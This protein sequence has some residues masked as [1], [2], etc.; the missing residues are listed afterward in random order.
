MRISVS[1]TRGKTTTVNMLHDMLRSRGLSVI[2]KTTGERAVVRDNTE[3]EIAE[4]PRSVLYENLNIIKSNYDIIIVE[5]QAIT[6]YTMRAFNLMVKPDIVIITNVRLDHTE[7]LG[8][9]REDIARSFCSSFVKSIKT[10]ISGEKRQEIGEILKKGAEKIGAS[11]VKAEDYEIPGS[12][13]VGIAEAVL[14]HVFGERM[15]YDE[16][17][18]MLK[19]LD[20]MFSARKSRSLFWY[21][22]AKI[23]DPDSAEIVLNYLRKKYNM[24]IAISANLRGDRRDRTAVFSVF[25][26]DFSK[27]DWVRRIF[28]SGP[29]SS[30][31][32]RFIGD[33]AIKVKED[34]SSADEIIDFV[35]REGLLLV[36]LVNRRTKMADILIEEL[37][38]G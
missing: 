2:S 5:N 7:F 38:K 11:Y 18:D 6:P 21:N 12:E 4:R 8:E 1:G 29:A 26:R 14:M 20:E 33:K 13:T 31:V 15:D 27:L 25:L 34:P 3:R 19:R 23:N 17:K 9:K 10:V 30:S 22:G 16:K 37:S 36:L 35:A 32:A 28:V 24:E